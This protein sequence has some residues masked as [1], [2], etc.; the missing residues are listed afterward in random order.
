MREEPHL[1]TASGS[2]SSERILYTP[3]PFAR[4]NLLH[5]QEVGS[6]R[7]L[8]PHTSRRDR[9]QSYL[10]FAVTDGS[11]MLEQ[12]G[13]RH[14]LSAGDV[15][16][17]D[18]RSAYAHS[19]GADG[20]LWSLWWCHFYGPTLPAIHAKYRERGGQSVVRPA[21]F[22]GY[23]QVLSE[24]YAL[25][26]SQDYIRDMRINE[27]L[28][29]LLTRLMEES[30]RQGERASV[31]RKMDVLQIKTYL[32][33][34]YQEHL[35]LESVA[36]H[37]FVDKSYLAR[38]FKEECGVTMTAY[39]QQVRITHAKRLLRFTDRRIEEIARLCGVGEM[40]YFGRVF[41]KLEGISPSEYRRLW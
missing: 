12:D 27:R 38:R 39:L 14:A 6:L 3:S 5:L 33:E 23:V 32:D 21:D 18:C 30:W 24:L 15:A 20:A 9:L 28:S 25:A 19:T 34:H 37:F 26:G 7:A 4:A 17:V 1:F 2:V 29:A 35:T 8:S 40:N 36:R 13:R 10:C 11:G 31:P 16:F 22:A 41:R